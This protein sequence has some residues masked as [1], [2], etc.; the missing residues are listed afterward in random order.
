M[1]MLSWVGVLAAALAGFVIGGLWYGPL[2]A[3]IWR[4]ETGLTNDMLNSGS[5]MAIFGTTFL[6]NLLAALFLSHS[7]AMAG[8]PSLR[9]CIQIAGGIGVFF[10]GTSIGVNYLFSRKS[11]RL[12]LIDAGYWAVTYTAMGAIL[13]LIG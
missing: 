12:F 13:G 9:Y 3:R 7:F 6:L 10:V 1:P 4:R 11:F 5:T 2:F 8:P